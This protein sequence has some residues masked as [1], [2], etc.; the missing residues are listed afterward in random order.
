MT[1]NYCVV[2][3]KDSQGNPN[4]GIYEVYYKENDL[5]RIVHYCTKDVLTVA[6]IF[7]RYRGEALIEESS[8]VIV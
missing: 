4:Y 5:P 3:T 6:Q 8:V 2:K 7:R 1:W